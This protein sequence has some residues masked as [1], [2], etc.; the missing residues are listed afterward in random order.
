MEED[1]EGQDKDIP[2]WNSGTPN[3]GSH[4]SELQNQQLQCVLDNHRD[5]L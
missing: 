2:V 1:Y 5:V 4:L 3:I